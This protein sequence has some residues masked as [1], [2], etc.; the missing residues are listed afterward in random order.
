MLQLT[1][2]PL[3]MTM[4]L[5][6]YA[7]VEPWMTGMPDGWY[8]RLG[9]AATVVGPFPSHAEAMTHAEARHKAKI[10]QAAEDRASERW[11]LSRYH[12]RVMT[13]H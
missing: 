1:S 8:Y 2:T 3:M 13:P 9:T 6:D 7:L 5:P 4:L 11:R 12:T 10:A